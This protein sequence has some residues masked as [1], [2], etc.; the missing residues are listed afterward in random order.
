MA[1]LDRSCEPPRFNERVPIENPPRIVR[2][3]R[4]ISIVYL[5]TQPFRVH[6]NGAII[7][8]GVAASDPD[9]IAK[10]GWSSLTLPSRV[11]LK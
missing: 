8:E 1:E 11:R 4:H 5:K 7:R 2:F 3:E 6:L 10:N 9:G